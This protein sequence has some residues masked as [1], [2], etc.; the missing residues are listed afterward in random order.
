LS[1]HSTNPLT[2]KQ[3]DEEE[4]RLKRIR[5]DE[6]EAQERE[7]KRK[8]AAAKAGGAAAGTS[9]GLL[10]CD[11][12]YA[13]PPSPAEAAW[14]GLMG[15]AIAVAIFGVFAIR[16]RIAARKAS[17]EIH[18]GKEDQASAV[19]TPGAAAGLG[20]DRHPQAPAGT[21]GGG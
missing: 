7:R 6:R 5:R 9:G 18:H 15:L 20:Q 3:Q 19:G 12:A 8:A 17:R 21:A 10:D 14:G 4:A 11:A 16:N 13:V 2:P 1:N